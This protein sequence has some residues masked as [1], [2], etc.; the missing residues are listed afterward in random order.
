MLFSQSY[1]IAEGAYLGRKLGPRY[2]TFGKYPT[3]LQSK[4][5][6]STHAISY[7]NL[8]P[9]SCRVAGEYF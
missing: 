6:S 7:A 3:P 8:A 2:E 1:F 4:Q 9:T 5:V